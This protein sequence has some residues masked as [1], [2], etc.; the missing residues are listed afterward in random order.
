M[1]GWVIGGVDGCV[2]VGGYVGVGVA[3]VNRGEPLRRGRGQFTTDPLPII[4]LKIP[5]IPTPV[6]TTTTITTTMA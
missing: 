6:T 5:S 1:S 3:P 4:V 2:G